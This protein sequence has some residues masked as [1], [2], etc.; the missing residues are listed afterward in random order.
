[1]AYHLAF[2]GVNDYV[3]TG[4]RA[5]SAASNANLEVD[6]WANSGETAQQELING[7]G[8]G[9]ITLNRAGLGIITFY[10]KLAA[11]WVGLHSPSPITFDERHVVKTTYNGVT[12]GVEL[13]I[14]GVVVATASGASGALSD[15]LDYVIGTK[16]ISLGDF[17]FSGSI[18]SATLEVNGTTYTY[19][20]SASGG[21]GSVLP[22]TTGSKSG[23][24]V[25]FPTDD[26]QWV[27]YTPQA[28]T[29]SNPAITNLLATSARLNWEQG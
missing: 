2:D 10:Y 17:P 18:Y 12:G 22:D 1:M 3:T 8:G 24:L 16:A 25:N 11:S 5:T 20:P 27:F 15:T 29:P 21:T 26:S 13:I 14:D 6:F 19:A 7:E 9:Q 28:A 4:L 23:T